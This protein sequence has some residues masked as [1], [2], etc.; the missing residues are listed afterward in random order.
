MEDLYTLT[1]HV[2]ICCSVTLVGHVDQQIIHQQCLNSGDCRPSQEAVV[3][4]EPPS[5]V[6]QG[7]AGG[8]TTST[9][10]YTSSGPGDEL[11]TVVS[12]LTDMNSHAHG[13]I[14]SQY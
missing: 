7:V 14:R 2:L 3:V 10:V 8:K 9:P 1:L 12:T 13:A 6:G 4:D 11:S 5:T